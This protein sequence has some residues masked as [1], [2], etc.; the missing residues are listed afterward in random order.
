LRVV[1]GTYG[2]ADDADARDKSIEAKDEAG[3][4]LEELRE[5]IGERLR[6]VV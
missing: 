4:M 3:L 2:A 1:K 5:L 6:A